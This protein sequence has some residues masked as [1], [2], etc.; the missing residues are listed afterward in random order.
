MENKYEEPGKSTFARWE[1]FRPESHK[2]GEPVAWVTRPSNMFCL[3]G[4]ANTKFSLDID[5]K[6][7]LQMVVNRAKAVEE[8]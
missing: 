2:H 1:S 6:E 5:E 8:D 3:T 4:K 7:A